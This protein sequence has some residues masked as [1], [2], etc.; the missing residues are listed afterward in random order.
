MKRA[1]LVFILFSLFILSLCLLVVSWTRTPYGMLDMKIAILLKYISV[2]QVD[3]FEEGRSIEQ[4]RGFSAKGGRMLQAAAPEVHHV[5][6]RT[7]PGPS[8]PVP[9]RVYADTAALGLPIVIYCHGGGWVLGSLDTHD[10]T[11]RNIAK[12]A[13]VVVLAPDYGLAPENPYPSGLNDVYAAL[14]WVRKNAGEIGG[15]PGKIFLAGD[16]AGGNLA[17]ATAIRA[18]ELSGPAIAG[19]ILIYP[20]VN[21]NDF[22]TASYG[23]FSKGHYLTRRYMEKF[24]AYYVPNLP[25]RISPLVSPLLAADLRGLPPALVVTAQF[26]ILRDEGEAYA[27]QL[28]KNGVTAELIRVKGVIHGFLKMD[29]ILS[30]ADDTFMDIAAFIH[31]TV[32]NSSGGIPRPGRIPD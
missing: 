25:D 10:N 30:Q 23:M 13:G 17:A 11:C 2:M 26:D 7:L 29:K 9:V 16:S 27:R 24:R 32:P 31:K 12:K 28:E 6:D 8:G 15:D 21:L 5:Q 20:A 22:S 1:K 18:R 19:Q 4:I 14:V 3:L